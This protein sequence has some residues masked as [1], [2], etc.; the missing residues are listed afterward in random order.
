MNNTQEQTL[1]GEVSHGHLFQLPTT[2]INHTSLHFI[3]DVQPSLRD[4]N[5]FP[6]ARPCRKEARAPR[7]EKK[8]FL[9]MPSRIMTAHVQS[10]FIPADFTSCL[11][12][13]LLL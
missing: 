11:R 8:Q 12:S 2:I 4:L 13:D 10:S 6:L 9:I 3:I 1:C 7:G 5:A